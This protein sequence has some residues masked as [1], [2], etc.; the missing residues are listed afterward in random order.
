MRSKAH[1]LEKLRG[2]LWA[3]V[4]KEIKYI[5]PFKLRN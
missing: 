3:G 4:P 5:H 2:K 1:V